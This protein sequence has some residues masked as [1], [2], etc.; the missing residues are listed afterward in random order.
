ME[1][2]NEAIECYSREM[3][4]TGENVR[5]LNNRGYSHAKIS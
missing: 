5:T 1:K 3:A 2:Y 4:L